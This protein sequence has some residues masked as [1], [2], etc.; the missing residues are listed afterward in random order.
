MES[1]G[2]LVTSAGHS[3]SS[4]VPSLQSSRKEWK[5]N[6]D[7]SLRDS[8]VQELERSKLSQSDEKTIYEQGTGPLDVDFCSIT[9]DNGVHDDPLQQRLRDVTR[10]RE[11]LQQMEIELRARVIAGTEIMEM[12]KSFES[13]LKDHADAY[14][15]LK[16]QLQEREE[17]IR[18]LEKK[19]EDMDR[20]L[21]AIKLD[22][23]KA[24]AK[25]D[26]LRE[27]NKELATFRRERDNSD[28][29]RAQHITQIHELKAHIQEKERQFLEL[30]EQ[31][32]V[33]QETIMYKDGQLREAQTWIA[34]VQEMDAFQLTANHSLQAELR[35]RT[36][37]YNQLW[38][39]CQRQLADMER[40]HMQTIQQLQAELAEARERCGVYNEDV[41][42]ARVNE[43]DSSQ[44]VQK[45]GNQFDVK[46]GAGSSSNS[47]VL[48]NGNT[49][50]SP[51]FASATSMSPKLDH[52]PAVT[53]VPSS[54]YGMNAFVPPGRVPPLHPYI[55][56]QSGIPHT[57]PSAN[58]HIS[59][60]QIG[61]YRPVASVQSNQY[62]MEQQAVP[63]NS[64]ISSQNQHLSAS[65]ME[66]SSLVSPICFEYEPSSETHGNDTDYS[67]SQQDPSQ[68]AVTVGVTVSEEGQEQDQA[69]SVKEASHFHDSSL[70]LSEPVSVKEKTFSEHEVLQQQDA[71]IRRDP[72]NPLPQGQSAS[73]LDRISHVKGEQGLTVEQLRA[74]ST[75]PHSGASPQAS[76]YENITEGKEGHIVLS[77]E[78]LLS[79]VPSGTQ[80]S[81]KVLEPTLLDEK[82]LLACI[83]RGIPAGNSGHI[84]ISTTLPNRLAK[85]LAPLHWHDYKKKY[86]KLDDFMAGHPE[87]FVIE[88]DF[89]HLREGAQA[90][91]SATT[92]VAKVAA[93]AAA[94]PSSSACLSTVSVTPAAQIQRLRKASSFVP[95][96]G[97]G[98][99]CVEH[100]AQSDG[101]D[102]RFN[103]SYP[104][105]LQNQEVNGV[106]CDRL[107]GTIGP[108]IKI[109]SNRKDGLVQNGHVKEARH[110]KAS[111]HDNVGRLENSGK[112]SF[113]DFHSTASMNERRGVKQIGRDKME[114]MGS[115]L[116]A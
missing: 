11:E 29:E 43:K 50:S 28:A 69:Q 57:V 8:G 74:S 72:A 52:V 22:N 51:P 49:E 88:G 89:V 84:R 32:R 70:K 38:L 64:K 79:S 41:S 59:Q 81:G 33:A 96:S 9:I 97:S 116:I 44:Y 91:I 112:A 94:L 68:A 31:H 113:I 98:I 104:W 80:M 4:S 103:Q 46:D 7:H 83:V 30:E 77:E 13:Q 14:A 1:G 102:A 62:T 86:G 53:V 85:M 63:E 19:M 16:E 67:T 10:Q 20:E 15:N 90:I 107:Q 111:S 26:L 99:S 108:N 55:M 66:Q 76:G 73:F 58:S 100:A 110:E 92:A 3:S 61:H 12:R 27:Q 115:Y 23:E 48:P 71:P 34:R 109:L 56:H 60:S 6:N 75:M 17:F 18:E 45:K 21:R 5:A 39:G 87:L 54:V 36:D 105:T 2:G 25:E 42:V 93:A 47:M 101:N 65:Q 106:S 82:S 114:V 95:K 78:R 35:E 40:H 37:Q 24:W